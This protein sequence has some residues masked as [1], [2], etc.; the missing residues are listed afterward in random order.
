MRAPQP[1]LGI[2]QAQGSGIGLPVLMLPAA[3][4]LAEC[5][6]ELST[7]RAPSLPLPRSLSPSKIATFKDCPLS[8]K[9]S[10]VDGLQEPASIHAVKGTLVHRALESL[11]WEMPTGERILE[12]AYGFAESELAQMSEDD[13]DLKA[14]E[15][16]TREMATL[17]QQAKALI[18]GYFRLEDP[19]AI[20]STGTEIALEANIGGTRLRGIID[21]LDMDAGGNLTITDYKTG[22]TPSAGFE[23]ARFN[24]VNIYALLCEEVIG[25]RPVKVQLLYLQQPCIL[26]SEPSEQVMH[27]TAKNV[28]ALWTAVEKACDTG[29]FLPR[30]SGLCG[31]CGFKDFCPAHGGTAPGIAAPGTALA[32]NLG[33]ESMI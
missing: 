21:R 16:P 22:R 25:V 5:L 28:S 15:L 30:P 9:F 2:F 7:R 11:F 12:R 8:F 17:L 14:L 23:K 26:S 33:G 18:D 27:A 29:N 32:V 10:Y 1:V 4:R 19:N 13:P 3:E 20:C 24:G 31:W 6:E